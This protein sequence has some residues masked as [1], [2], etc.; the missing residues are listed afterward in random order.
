MGD[1]GAGKSTCVKATTKKIYSMLW[2]EFDDLVKQATPTGALLTRWQR[3][4]L[5]YIGCLDYI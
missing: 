4:V 3:E 5:L 2:Y 1:P